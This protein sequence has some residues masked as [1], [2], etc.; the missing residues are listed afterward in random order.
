MLSFL[1]FY[2]FFRT[3]CESLPRWLLTS[4]MSG[5]L[6]LEYGMNAPARAVPQVI[7]QVMLATLL[8]GNEVHLL[9]GS[10]CGTPLT[11][12]YLFS[13]P[14]ALSKAHFFLFLRTRAWRKGFFPLF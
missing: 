1:F 5:H 14:A 7:P 6:Q 11:A 13:R 3:W 12:T 10:C 2:S 4:A 9:R 8:K